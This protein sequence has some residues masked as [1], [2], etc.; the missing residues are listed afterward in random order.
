M[1][2]DN[3]NRGSLFKNDKG[4]NEKRP[5]YTGSLNVEGTDYKLS[6]WIKESKDGKK[7]M[8]ISVQ[9]KEVKDPKA[10]HNEAKKNGYVPQGKSLDEEFKDDIPF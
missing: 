5:D 1:E 10:A 8:S 3:T 9:P 6:A 7:Y 4:D 2:Y